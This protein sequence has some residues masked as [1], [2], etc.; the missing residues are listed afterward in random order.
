M[1]FVV[2]ADIFGKTSAL[3]D[4]VSRIS[5]IFTSTLLIDP[6]E[7][8]VMSFAREREAYSYFQNN[9]GLSQYIKIVAER[10]KHRK[11][12][13]LLVG[14][15]IGASVVWRVSQEPFFHPHT[16]AVGFYGSQIRNHLYVNPVI[17]ID[18]YFPRHEPHFNVLELIEEVSKK[19]L[20]R[21]IKTDYLHGFMNER[22][23]NYD[24]VGYSEYLTLLRR[25]AEQFV[26]HREKT[27][28]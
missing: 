14:F 8:Q 23:E 6:Y 3:E 15:S 4:L 13:S 18:L 28:S 21:A 25:E 17:E 16:K 26:L 7:G 10:V 22:S 19:P 12:S 24:N 1:Q 2:V 27:K 9:I 20:A 11:V 5:S